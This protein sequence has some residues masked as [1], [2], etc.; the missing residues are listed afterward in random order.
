MVLTPSFDAIFLH[1]HS[2]H[3]YSSLKTEMRAGLMR[4]LVKVSSA[5][6]SPGKSRS[7]SNK[8]LQTFNTLENINLGELP[9]RS[10][11]IH[12]L[13]GLLIKKQCSIMDQKAPEGLTSLPHKAQLDLNPQATN[14]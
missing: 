12:K 4:S 9:P 11:S 7:K 13:V 6:R 10:L 5:L 14:R 2:T 1:M 8:N 3:T